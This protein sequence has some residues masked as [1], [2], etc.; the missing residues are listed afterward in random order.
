M[1]IIGT[2]TAEKKEGRECEIIIAMIIIGG[3]QLLL[4]VVG[5]QPFIVC[6]SPTK[7]VHK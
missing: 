2:L 1:A 5:F 6:I 4:L 3:S 7:G